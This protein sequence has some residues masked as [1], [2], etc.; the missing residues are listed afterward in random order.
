MGRIKSFAALA[1]GAAMLAAVS[2]TPASSATVRIGT[3]VCDVDGGA[4][5]I[6]GSRKHLDCDFNHLTGTDEFYDGTI[7]KLG[8]DAGLPSETR[9]IWAVFAPSL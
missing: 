3:L 6:L 7:T 9:L 4:G 5:F 2:A 1:A 8:I